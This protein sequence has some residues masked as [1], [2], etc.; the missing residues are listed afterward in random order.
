MNSLKLKEK[1]EVKWEKIVNTSFQWIEA[2]HYLC[3]FL[4][5]LLLLLLILN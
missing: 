4:D 2:L 5:L 1:T 3:S